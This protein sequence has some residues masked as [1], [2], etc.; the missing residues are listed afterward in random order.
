[1]TAQQFKKKKKNA[2]KMTGLIL[3]QKSVRIGDMA[4]SFT[5]YIQSLVHKT[6]SLKDSN[7]MNVMLPLPKQYCD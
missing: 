6:T 3:M 2:E 7:M 1:M 5:C 4:H